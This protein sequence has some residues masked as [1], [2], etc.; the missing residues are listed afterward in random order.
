MVLQMVIHIAEQQV[1]DQSPPQLL[2]IGGRR[3]SQRADNACDLGV[4]RSSS[5]EAW[6]RDAVD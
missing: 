6:S 4:L 1:E 3:M 5:R 2:H